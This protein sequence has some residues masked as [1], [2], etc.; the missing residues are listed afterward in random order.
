MQGRVPSAFLLGFALVFSAVLPAHT[1]E[2]AKLMLSYDVDPTTLIIKFRDDAKLKFE[3]GN[4]TVNGR[5]FSLSL[6]NLAS[7]HSFVH[8]GDGGLSEG[9]RVTGANPPGIATA[10]GR[11]RNPSVPKSGLTGRRKSYPN[12]ALSAEGRC[13]CVF[14]ATCKECGIRSPI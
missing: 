7:P 4:L 14:R 5:T 1:L 9:T 12:R 13:L 2:E 11:L 8:Q 6:R 10:S 3:R